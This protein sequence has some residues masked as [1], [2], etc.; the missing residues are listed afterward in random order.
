VRP[1]QTDDSNV[2]LILPE[3]E[4]LPDDKR[5]GDLFVERVFF[6]DEETGDQKPGFESVWKPADGERKAL[7][8]GALITLRLWGAN[9]PPV[10]M[11]VGD[12][13]EG[14]AL[15]ALVTVEEARKAAGKFFDRL[16]VRMEEARGDGPELAADEI[17]AMFNLA[18]Q[19][20]VRHR[21]TPPSANGAGPESN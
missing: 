7:A 19:E 21:G 20:V 11:L 12:P 14:E 18:L 3:E 13:P 5:R 8:N 10:N 15:E 2:R 9:H 4:H 16:S 1:V 17:P 6:A